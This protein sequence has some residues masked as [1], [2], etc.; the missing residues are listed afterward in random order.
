MPK[1]PQLKGELEHLRLEQRELIDELTANDA[2]REQLKRRL[3]H[4]VE[5]RG[6]VVRARVAGRA[7]TMQRRADARVERDIEAARERAVAA[8]AA[9]EKDI[10]KLRA[11]LDAARADL[12]TANA[13]VAGLRVSLNEKED[14]I[15]GLT[16]R[17]RRYNLNATHKLEVGVCVCRG[18]ARHHPCP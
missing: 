12:R 8:V 2:E 14:K 15:A 7:A 9:V 1:K 11:E 17:A 3:A 6:T 16:K 13:T 18:R 4:D 5:A 10:A